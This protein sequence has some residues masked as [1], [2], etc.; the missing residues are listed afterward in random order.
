VL[1]H[2]PLRIPVE[3][4]V[5]LRP[6]LDAGSPLDGEGLEERRDLPSVLAQPGL[7]L[8]DHV[9]DGGGLGGPGGVGEGAGLVEAGPNDLSEYIAHLVHH[10]ASPL[11]D[12][13]RGRGLGDPDDHL[14]EVLLGGLHHADHQGPETL[15]ARALTTGE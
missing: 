4:E 8:G 10:V 3:V 2:H 12:L 7:P 14:L 15:D 13:L 6:L 5:A 1:S 11:E 9:G